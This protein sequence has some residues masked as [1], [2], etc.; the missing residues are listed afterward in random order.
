MQIDERLRNYPIKFY[1]NEDG[2]IYYE[3][4]FVQGTAKTLDDAFK[5][6]QKYDWEHDLIYYFAD[7]TEVQF[8]AYEPALKDI[9]RKG[10]IYLGKLNLKLEVDPGWGTGKD[11]ITHLSKHPE[12]LPAQMKFLNK[13]RNKEKRDKLIKSIKDGFKKVAGYFTGQQYEMFDPI[14][15]RQDLIC[16]HCGSI[17]PV[18]TYYEY[19]QGNNY[20]LECIW[21]KLCNECKSN[22]YSDC[23]E[24]FFGL[25]EHIGNW[26]AMGLDIEDDYLIDLDLVKSNDRR[27]GINEEAAMQQAPQKTFEDFYQF[28]KNNPKLDQ[29]YYYICFNGKIRIP[30]DTINHAWKKHKTTCEQWLD[31]LSNLSNI[32]NAQQ[33]TDKNLGRLSYLCRIIGFKNYGIVLADCPQYFYVM[34]LFEDTI[35]SIDN[36]IKMGSI[37]RSASQLQT[38]VK[39]Q[40]SDSVTHDQYQPNNIITYIVNKINS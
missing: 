31:A 30:S 10:K 7:V 3:A 8:G 24:F 17:I 27:V 19:Y 9:K 37:G 36:W 20:H 2:T 34:T 28:C 18:A 33:S 29:K 12:D 35:V 15:T 16:K 1:K 13:M 5:Q 11:S 38:P 6:L 21:D 25:Q 4:A 39:S 14:K 40:G 32:I 23:R 22:D 26:P